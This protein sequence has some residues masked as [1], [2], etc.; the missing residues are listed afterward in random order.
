MTEVK[1]RTQISVRRLYRVKRWMY[2]RG[3]PGGLARVMNRI[4]AIQFSAGIL[5]PE[6]AATLEVPG[7]RSGRT[8]S[9]PV[10]VADYEGERYLVSMLGEDANWVQTPARP[11]DVRCCDVDT[12]RLCASMRSTPALVRRSCVATWPSRREPDPT[13]PWT[14]APL[15][16]TSSG[17]PHSSLSSGSPHSRPDRTPRQHR[18]WPAWSTSAAPPAREPQR[19][20]SPSDPRSPADMRS[21][22]ALEELSVSGETRHYRVLASARVCATSSPTN[23]GLTPKGSATGT[24]GQA[25]TT[26]SVSLPGATNREATAGL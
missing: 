15:C 3:G 16:G 12:P 1:G 13:Y 20:A 2:R 9:F 11:E 17:S 26:E 21:G 25:A 24:S 5:S 14:V 6:R 10:V 8:I 7:R 18:G 22:V 23:A 4:S 19:P